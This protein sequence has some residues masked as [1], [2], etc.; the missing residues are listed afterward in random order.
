M[1]QINHCNNSNLQI[2]HISFQTLV[3]WNMQPQ[4]NHHQ[5]VTLY[6]NED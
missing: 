6:R 2:S 3:A 1:S 4:K 5:V